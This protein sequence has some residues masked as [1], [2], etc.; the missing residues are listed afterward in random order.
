MGLR[1]IGQDGIGIGRR[2]AN[3]RLSRWQRDRDGQACLYAQLSPQEELELLAGGFEI[4]IRPGLENRLIVGI[5]LKGAGGITFQLRNVPGKDFI[6]S[7]S[8]DFTKNK[9]VVHTIKEAPGEFIELGLASPPTQPSRTRGQGE[10][11]RAPSLGRPRSA[12]TQ[13]APWIRLK[14]A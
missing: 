9:Y 3:P 4:K 8:F 14:L 13:V 2:K 11:S 1:R 12:W 5:R 7:T 10:W 6:S